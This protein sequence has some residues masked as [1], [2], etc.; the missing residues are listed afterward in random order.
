MFTLKKYL[1]KNTLLKLTVY[2]L[3]I[4]LFWL[5]MSYIQSNIFSLNVENPNEANILAFNPLSSIFLIFGIGVLLAGRRGMLVSYILG[6]LLL[7][8]NILFY[9][10]YNDFITIPMLNQ[11]ANLAGMG[12]SIQTILEASDIF[13]FVD[14]LIA[15]F[16]L[17]YLKPARLSQFTPKRREGFL[18][19]II[20]I[21]LFVINLQ[22]AEEERT[23][24]LERTFDRTMLVKYIGL[25]NYHVYDAVLQGKTEM[26][27][28]LADSNELVPV[29]NYLNEQKTEDSDRLE[30]VAEGKNVIAISLE[31]TQ[32]FVVDN[33][34]HGE[35]VTPYFNELKEEGMY[36]DNFYHQVKQGRTSDSE[37]LLA[38]S[39]YP[40]NRGAVFFTHSGNEYEAMPELLSENGY[41]TNVMHANDKT[42]WNRNVMYDS[43]GYNEFFSKED[44]DVT[45]E[46]SHGWGYLDE[47]FFED[48]LEKMKEMEEP[49]YSKMI[50]LTHHYPFTLPEELAT[51]EQGETSSTTLN[52]YFQTIR[53]QDEALEQFVEEFKQSELYDDT[54]LLIYGDHFGI[55]ENHQKAMG[56]YLGKEINDYE[57]FQLQRVPML[58]YG[59]DIPSE[60]NHTVG[61]QIDLRPTLTNLL[62]IED[63]NPVQFGQD[64]LNEDRREM[65]ITRDGDF[66]NEEYVGI[67]GVCYDRETGEQVEGQACEEG[68][69]TAQEELSVSDSVIYGD[70]LRYLD[71]TEMVNTD[72]TLNKN[73]KEE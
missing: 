36:F 61:G 33:T 27:K 14:V 41:F 9:R 50:T 68:F 8:V 29:I 1:N 32:T 65:M 25:L 12:G 30:G 53:Y 35:E 10:E 47:Y 3:V 46:K 26:K 55:S 60:T 17:F 73:N 56:E 72:P 19:A 57:Q 66:A 31:S 11:V 21:P 28:T 70:L 63:E 52:R 34:L 42:F 38:N 37:F 71:E 7:Y 5:K 16:F 64:L 18:L 49:F 22:W 67:Q 69:Q 44:Y 2:A 59:K 51:I 23:D 43:L 39:M 54:I 24:L 15:A 62:G 6:S 4:G 48:S 45:P 13:L 40:L 58:I 20:A